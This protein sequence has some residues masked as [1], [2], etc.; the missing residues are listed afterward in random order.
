MAK[1]KIQSVLS[2]PF[3][4]DTPL[5]TLYADSFVREFGTEPWKA[6]SPMPAA[7]THTESEVTID[8]YADMVGG[9]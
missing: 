8:Q 1:L 6:V 4:H 3:D 7:R 5:E 2:I 9:N